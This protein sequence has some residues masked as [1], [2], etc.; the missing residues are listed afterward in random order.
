MTVK[1]WAALLVPAAGWAQD[2]PLDLFSSLLPKATEHV[3]VT[4]DSSLVQL[5]A[6]F[7]TNDN[8]G[9]SKAI[10]DAKA[11]QLLSGLKGIYVR[12]LTFAKPGEYSRA[13]VEK[14]Q[15]QLKGWNPIVS[16]HEAGEDTGIYIKTD[17]QKIQGI[18]ILSAEPTEL[19][20]VNIVGTI[21][22]ED[23]K[24]LSGKFGIPD[25][26]DVGEK[27]GQKKKEE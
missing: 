20:L 18:V 13:D 5:A 21:Q 10:E 22:L 12:S 24:N 17:G 1:I 15:T 26:G 3:E 25:L 27:A 23:L 16:V 11:K 2:V 4:L 9:T 6:S 19:T 8:H 14:I 7:L